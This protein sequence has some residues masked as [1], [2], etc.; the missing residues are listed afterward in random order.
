MGG[1]GGCERRIKVIVEIQ[2][3]KTFFFWGGGLGEGSA[4]GVRV[5]NIEELKFFGKIHKKNLGGGGGSAGGGL[6]RG[7]VGMVWG[8]GWIRTKN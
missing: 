1:Q 7:G 4:L 8:S 3:K 6:G 2:K 5:D